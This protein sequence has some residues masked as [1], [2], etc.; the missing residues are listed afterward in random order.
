MRWLRLWVAAAAAIASGVLLLYL[1]PIVL[2]SVLGP[3]PLALVVI[4]LPGMVAGA[5]GIAGSHWRPS[6]AA[7]GVQGPARWADAA[8]S[9]GLIAASVA[10]AAAILLQ[11][12]LPAIVRNSTGPC[13]RSPTAACFS[14]HRDYYQEVPAGSG[15]FTTPASRFYEGVL[16]PVLLAAWP[17]A[18][19]AG[20]AGVTALASRTRRR[21]VAVI[22]VILGSIT[23]V[24][25]PMTYLAFLATG[26]D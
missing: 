23:V 2:S 12:G 7:A 20:V 17:L 5:A 18:L 8:A 21:R 24:G 22:G 1:G 3:A 19:A 14:A 10:L 6:A 25:M 11:F 15:G 13:D 26:G 9:G 4:G 16:V